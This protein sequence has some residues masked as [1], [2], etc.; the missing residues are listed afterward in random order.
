MPVSQVFDRALQLALQLDLFSDLVTPAQIKT[1]GNTANPLAQEP[2]PASVPVT[3][4]ILPTLPV[5]PVS[6]VPPVNPPAVQK[7][8]PDTGSDAVRPDVRLRHCRCGDQIISYTLSRSSRRSIGLSVRDSQLHIT[9]PHRVTIS[10]VEEAIIAKQRWIRNKIQE[11]QNRPSARQRSAQQWSDGASLPFMGSALQLGF[12]PARKRI[13]L[14]SAQRL[15]LPATVQSDE[16]RIRMLV[17]GWLKQQALQIFEQKIADFALRLGVTV[18][19]VSLS[20]ARTRWGSCTTQGD[21]RLNWRLIFL[22][23]TMMDYVVAHEL[24]HRREMNHSPRFWAQV[25]AIYPDY[26]N[27]RKQLQQYPIS[28]LPL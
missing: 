24:A 15:E 22:P 28:S 13:G 9:A 5:S 26:R 20:S 14:A 19:Q 18:R 16:A 25:E 4:L 6:S 23:E 8:A 21:I 11:Q 2:V 3:P 17:E 1:R 7:P 27:V 10:A 12:D